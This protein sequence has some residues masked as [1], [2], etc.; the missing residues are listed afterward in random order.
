MQLNE[1]QVFVDEQVGAQSHIFH[2]KKENLHF[3]S[4]D[5]QVLLSTAL[6]LRI[7]FLLIFSLSFLLCVLSAYAFSLSLSGFFLTFYCSFL[8]FLSIGL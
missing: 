8:L 5:C 2:Q 7:S 4:V 3:M 1:T 6:S